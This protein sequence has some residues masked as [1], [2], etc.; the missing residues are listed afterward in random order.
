MYACDKW[1]TYRLVWHFYTPAAIILHFTQIDS[2][3]QW[4]E[5]QYVIF[6]WQ[7]R[8]WR[9]TY[10]DNYS[11]VHIHHLKYRWFLS[12]QYGQEIR[13][14]RYIRTHVSAHWALQNLYTR[15]RAIIFVQ[16]IF[17]LYHLWPPNCAELYDK[18]EL[19][20]ALDLRLHDFHNGSCAIFESER[21]Y[22]TFIII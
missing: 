10:T 19:E 9:W 12:N 4:Y 18:L 3:S 21:F 16:G 1:L 11:V 15:D 17:F 2:I 5:F 8:N 6:K 14:E 20:L 7:F 22:W 13:V